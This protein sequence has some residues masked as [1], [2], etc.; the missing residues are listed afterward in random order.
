[1]NTTIIEVRTKGDLSTNPGGIALSAHPGDG[2]FM[3]QDFYNNPHEPLT[4][5]YCHG[6]YDLTLPEALE[7]FT[8]RVRRA[9][10]YDAGGALLADTVTIAADRKTLATA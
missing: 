2:S 7:E 10:R 4:R 6:A 3:V 8:R 9:E 5:N 1:M